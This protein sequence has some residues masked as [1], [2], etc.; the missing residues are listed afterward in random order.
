MKEILLISRAARGDREALGELVRLYYGKIYNYIFYRVLDR[1]LAEDLTQDVFVKLTKSIH[2]YVPTA[3]F[4][5]YLYRIAHNTTVDY[6]RAAKQ[7][8]A[9]PENQAAPDGLS[10][11]DAKVDVHRML[12]VLPAEQ[13]ECIILY[14]LQGLT[15]WEISQILDIPIP[16][17]KSRVQRGLAVCRKMMEESS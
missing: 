17:A 6:F 13:R 2:S 16:T 10:A 11:V 9:I 15:Y 5:S 8:E 12:S 7:S 3:S 1:A 14:Y 4:S